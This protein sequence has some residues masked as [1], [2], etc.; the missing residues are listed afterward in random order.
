MQIVGEGQS[1]QKQQQHP[2]GESSAGAS[3]QPHV[4]EIREEEV[5]RMMNDLL[6][7]DTMEPV[8]ENERTW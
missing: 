6:R 5:S 2:R 7:T 4:Q 8:S 1:P 3:M